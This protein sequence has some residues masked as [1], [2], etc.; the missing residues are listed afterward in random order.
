MKTSWSVILVLAAFSLHCLRAVA[1]MKEGGARLEGR[2]TICEQN[3]PARGT[4]IWI[5][6]AK[7][8]EPFPV[9]QDKNGEFKISLHEGYYFV[10]IANLGL[11]PYAK[12][13]QVE[14]GKTEKLNV[15]LEPDFDIMQDS[16][17]R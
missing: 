1:Q 5:F 15:C 16:Q 10:F 4:K 17:S 3:V 9:Q 14:Q 11:K 7:T 12:E 8:L 13:V 6:E 2:I